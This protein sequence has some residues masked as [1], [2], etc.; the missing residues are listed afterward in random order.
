MGEKREREKADRSLR[1]RSPQLNTSLSSTSKLIDTS[2]PFAISYADGSKTSG[3]LY[4]DTVKVGGYNVSGQTLS[5]VTTMS[6]SFSLSN[7]A[8]DG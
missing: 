2:V 6:E 5:P 4:S 8:A 3:P 1:L 7:F